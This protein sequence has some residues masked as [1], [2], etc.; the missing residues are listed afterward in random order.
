MTTSSLPTTSA[1]GHI[2]MVATLKDSKG[3]DPKY[4]GYIVAEA[5]AE[6]AENIV[7]KIVHTHDGV[8]DLGEISARKLGDAALLPGKLRKL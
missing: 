3:A 6:K 1:T 7:A 8:H 5:D 2:V 4:S